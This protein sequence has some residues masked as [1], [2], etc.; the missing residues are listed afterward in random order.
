MSFTMQN[1]NKYFI[2]QTIYLKKCNFSSFCKV[3]FA[4]TAILYQHAGMFAVFGIAG[5]VGQLAFLHERNTDSHEQ[6]RHG[7]R[8]ADKTVD[9]VKRSVHDPDTPPELDLAEIVRMPAVFPKADIAVL[10]G[11]G[12]TEIVYLLVGNQLDGR[13]SDTYKEAQA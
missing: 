8:A 12:G 3:E 4:K 2:S 9:S 5:F 11:I 7:N 10:A 6:R 13:R 1:Y